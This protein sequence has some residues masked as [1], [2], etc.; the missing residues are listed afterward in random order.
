MGRRLDGVAPPQTGLHLPQLHPC[1]AHLCAV[2][3]AH[4]LGSRRLHRPALVR[5]C[6]RAAGGAQQQTRRPLEGLFGCYRI[7]GVCSGVSGDAFG[8]VFL[9]RQQQLRRTQKDNLIQHPLCSL[10]LPPTPL[11]TSICPPVLLLS[12][13]IGLINI[14]TTSPATPPSVHLAQSG[15]PLRAETKQHETTGGGGKKR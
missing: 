7:R 2:Y 13:L 11:I 10:L 9:C 4:S 8:G 12:P 1:Y 15:S 5:R 14:N 6:L 3:D